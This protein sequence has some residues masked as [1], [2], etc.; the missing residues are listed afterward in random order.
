MIF[1]PWNWYRENYSIVQSQTK[2]IKQ[3][4]QN[5]LYIVKCDNLYYDRVVGL[6]VCFLN[7][8]S[9]VLNIY[10]IYYTSYFFQILKKKNTLTCRCKLMTRV[11]KS[12]VFNGRVPKYKSRCLFR[13]WVLPESIFLI[14]DK[15]LILTIQLIN[16]WKWIRDNSICVHSDYI[17]I[18]I[19]SRYTSTWA[20]DVV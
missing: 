20:V 6:S 17:F 13:I 11:N 19:V 2:N 12:D 4:H 1:Q 7:K 15:S 16:W 10:L 8:Y 3:L 18:S 5:V 14:V 9:D